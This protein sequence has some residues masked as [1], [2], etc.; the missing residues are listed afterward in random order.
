MTTSG[1]TTTA[2]PM[3]ASPV[4]EGEILAGKYRVD[5]VL[6]E[7]GMGVVVAARHLS[8]DEPVAIKFLLPEV[9]QNAEAVE[10]FQREARAAIKIKSEHVVRVMDVGTL[11]TG[12]PYMVME[13][14]QGSDLSNLLGARGPLPVPEACDFVLQGCEA[15]ADAH[16]LGIVHR[17]LKPANLF[18]THRTDGSTC[19]KVLDFGI[20][21]TTSPGQMSMTKTTAVMGSP[22]Y[23]SPEQ[24]ASSR[25]VD[26]RADIWSIGAI[27]YELLT[28]R[29]PFMGDTLPEVC[30]AIIQGTPP[31]MR[32]VRPDVPEKLEHVILKCMAKD[33][34]QRWQNVAELAAALVEFAPRGARLS[35]ERIARVI[36]AAGLSASAIALPPS[37]GSIV[38]AQP[39]APGAATAA[40]WAQSTGTGRRSPAIPI[41]IGIGV[42]F[43]A[44][45]AIVAVVLL[46]RPSPAPAADVDP[47]KVA[48][49][50]PPGPTSPSTAV[51]S[52]PAVAKPAESAE[53]AASAS[54]AATPVAAGPPAR[55]AGRTPPGKATTTGTE[56]KPPTPPPTKASKGLDLF[57]DNK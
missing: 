38:P 48:P 6:G 30:S 19:M 31:P 15:I 3:T 49:S 47:A 27:L 17:D 4:H 52:V 26:M 22:L 20:S 34:A 24:M 51:G 43:L 18:L 1:P 21:K 37:S 53:P 5:R 33:R 11:E 54:T 55:T 29:P 23:M 32:E 9:M 16:A 44:A 40:S 13:L 10:R 8:L 56:P 42:V 50:A 14:L 12:A 28:A 7:G 2:T 25:N 39:G 57:N 41:A 35:A 45:V 36:G 46:R